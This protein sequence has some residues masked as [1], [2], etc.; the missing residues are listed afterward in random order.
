MRHAERGFTLLEV[1]VAMAVFAVVSLALLRSAGEQARLAAGMEDRLLAHWVASNTLTDL[2]SGNA[3]P[4]LG[5]LETSTVMAGRDWYV[6]ITVAPT[7]SSDVRHVTVAV[8][9]YDPDQ[10]ELPSPVISNV[11]FVRRRGRG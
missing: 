4:D 5:K 3:F 6:F 2:Q 1:L 11:G 8:A 10:A 9:P 7:P